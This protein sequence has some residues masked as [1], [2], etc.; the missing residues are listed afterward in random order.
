MKP[1]IKKRIEELNSGKIPKGYKKTEFGVFPCDW[2]LI[3]LKELLD[4]KN[5]VNADK[6]KYNSG[7]KMISVMDS[8]T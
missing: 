5:G 1:E 3:S 6:E 7:V 4:F 8:I 2:K